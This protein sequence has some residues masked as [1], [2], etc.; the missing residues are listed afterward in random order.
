M[1]AR[2]LEAELLLVGND[3]EEKLKEVSMTAAA[4]VGGPRMVLLDGANLAWGTMRALA[5]VYT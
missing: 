1:E 3:G 5:H 2:G 4:S